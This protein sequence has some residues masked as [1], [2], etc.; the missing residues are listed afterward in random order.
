MRP[1]HQMLPSAAVTQTQ[2]QACSPTLLPPLALPLRR[3]EYPPVKRALLWAIAELGIITCDMVEVIGGA[4]ALQTLTNGA[5]P[6]YAGE[7]WG[8]LEGSF[9]GQH[10]EA[11][12]PCPHPA[13]PPTC[14]EEDVVHA[15][16]G[17][18]LSPPPAQAC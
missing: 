15:S 14:R 6:L 10:T 3:A 12:V 5:V 18:T 2:P 7:S 9:E 8:G 17:Q 4:V 11:G 13:E 1:V 16:L